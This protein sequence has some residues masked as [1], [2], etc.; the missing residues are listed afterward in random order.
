[1]EGEALGIH[2]G[3]VARGEHDD[4]GDVLGAQHDDLECGAAPSGSR[5]TRLQQGER[6]AVVRQADDDEAHERHHLRRR[7]DLLPVEGEDLQLGR[8][9]TLRTTTPS[10][11]AS[12]AGAKLSTER[13]P[14][15]TRASQACWA[16]SERGGDDADGEAVV[17]DQRG[18]VA[19]RAHPLAGDPLAD[20]ARVAVE[21]RDDP[22]APLGEAAVGGERPAQ[23][24]HADDGD[25]PVLGEAEG[26]R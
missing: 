21:Q 26:A 13:T 3:A 15:A 12:T 24:A 7:G 18:Q 5:A 23:V 22:E 11:T 1:M 2:L 10:G 20:D 17:G 9:S 16:P 14:A 4:L 25:R 6:R 19:H 8:R